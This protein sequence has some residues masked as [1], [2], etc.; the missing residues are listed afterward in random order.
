M[1]IKTMYI[2]SLDNDLIEFDKI[3]YNINFQVCE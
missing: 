1:Y 2:V 3:I